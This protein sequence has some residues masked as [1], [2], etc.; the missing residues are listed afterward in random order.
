MTGGGMG[1]MTGGGMGG[2]TGGGMG[3]MTGN[4]MTGTGM[5]VN[6]SFT[7]NRGPQIG[8]PGRVGPQMFRGGN[9]P[10]RR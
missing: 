3:G 1:G 4:G 8:G 10:Y 6:K 7:P 5:G 9:T 2:M